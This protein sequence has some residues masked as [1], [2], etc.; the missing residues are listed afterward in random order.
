LASN[1]SL[2]WWGPS[3]SAT[4]PS[5]LA[6]SKEVRIKELGRFFLLFFIIIVFLPPISSIDGNLDCS[7]VIIRGIIKI[8]RYSIRLIILDV[9]ERGEL[10]KAF[11]N[12]P[13]DIM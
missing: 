2:Q 10:N 11:L 3:G 6:P 9:S 8:K 1:A 12:G 4:A 7:R 5:S 13:V